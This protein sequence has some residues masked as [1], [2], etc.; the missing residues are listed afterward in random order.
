MQKL[1]SFNG[2]QDHLLQQLLLPLPTDFQ[3]VSGVRQQMFPLLA[4]W[5][6]VPKP[7]FELP[8][9]TRIRDYEIQEKIG[10]GGMGVVYR[11]IHLRLANHCAVKVIAPSQ[12][13]HPECAIRFLREMQAAGKCRHI[14]LITAYDAGECDGMYYLAMELIVGSTLKDMVQKHGPFAAG[15]VLEIARQIASGLHD[16][17]EAGLV[18]RDIKP[19]NVMLTS[20]GVVKILDLGL[21]TIHGIPDPTNDHTATEAPCTTSEDSITRVN[22]QLGTQSYMAPEQ[23]DNPHAVDARADLF[24]LGCT[25]WYLLTGKVYPRNTAFNFDHHCRTYSIPEQVRGLL[26][27]LLANSPEDRFSDASQVIKAI[28]RIGNRKPN[29]MRMTSLWVGGFVALM[30]IWLASE[31]VFRKLRP[32]QEPVVSVNQDPEIIPIERGP[33]PSIYH[34]APGA[35]V[36]PMTRDEAKQLQTK[37]AEYVQIQ[38]TM[39]NR[40]GIEMVIIPPGRYLIGPETMSEVV[41]SKPYLI[42][43]REITRRQFQQ[44]IQAEK[45]TTYMENINKGV[46]YRTET[47]GN[48]TI[49]KQVVVPGIHCDNPGYT[50]ASL[51]DPV[52]HITHSEALLFC[53]WLSKVEQRTYRLPTEAEWEWAARAGVASRF[54]PEVQSHPER[55]LNI[56]WLTKNSNMHPHP[57]GQLQPNA[58]GLFDCLGNVAEWCADYFGEYPPGVHVDPAGTANRQAKLRV[59]RGGCY[60][61]QF[62]TYNDRRAFINYMGRSDVGFRIVCEP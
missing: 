22:Q 3:T 4:T 13:H 34:P 8:R 60:H 2:Q 41:I 45:R 42:G 31:A 57:T 30:I 20:S 46:W 12:M 6:N 18:H 54:P 56:A 49:E 27:S 35:G 24:S 9:G 23:C 16:A 58:W 11:A 47:S 32:I 36:L 19:S 53:N 48:S 38:P 43:T 44:F 5:Q 39:T 62:T 1:H 7:E 61:S 55:W 28:D 14:N 52:V 10:S 50:P 15:K 25:C 59:Y 37:W 40:F 21:A 29:R 33:M 26:V 51:D 17:H